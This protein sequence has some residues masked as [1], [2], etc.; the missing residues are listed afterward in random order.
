MYGKKDIKKTRKR[1]I[2]DYFKGLGQGFGCLLGS[3]MF[4][5][6][7]SNSMTGVWPPADAFENRPEDLGCNS[8]NYFFAT[9]TQSKSKTIITRSIFFFTLPS[10][11]FDPRSL[12]AD[13]RR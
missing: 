2:G 11:G 6:P 10:R 9:V 13:S 7:N 8:P 1:T 12:G 3:S 4:T 5:P